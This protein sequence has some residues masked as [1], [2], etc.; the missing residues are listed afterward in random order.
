MPQAGH[1][2]LTGC[3]RSGDLGQARFTSFVPVLYFP[4]VKR[5]SWTESEALKCL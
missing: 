1:L 3:A 5:A 4:S 2:N